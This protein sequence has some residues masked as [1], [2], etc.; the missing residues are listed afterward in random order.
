[1]ARDLCILP[2]KAH[3]ASIPPP[4]TCRRCLALVCQVYYPC[5][6]SH[7]VQFES[8]ALGGEALPRPAHFCHFHFVSTEQCHSLKRIRKEGS[9]CKQVLPLNIFLPE[10]AHLTD[11]RLKADW[12]QKSRRHSFARRRETFVIIE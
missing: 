10:L 4:L 5:Q 6:L 1:M 9:E 7:R 2:M 11:V 8:F 12:I 3:V